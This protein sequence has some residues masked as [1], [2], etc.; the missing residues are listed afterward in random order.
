[1]L[2]IVLSIGT[3]IPKQAFDSDNAHGT[4]VFLR[5]VQPWFGSERLVCA[6]SFFAT[7]N[8]ANSL[9]ETGLRF[10][11]VVKNATREFPMKHL[12]E[13]TLSNRNDFI[14]MVSKENIINTGIMAL[15]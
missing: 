7:V 3:K 4:A 6:D 13:M 2:K 10:T 5:L 1:M 12:S 8:T 11:G 14:T 15:M 9:M